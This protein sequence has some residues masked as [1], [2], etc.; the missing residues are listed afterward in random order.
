MALAR[1]AVRLS[2][3]VA[4]PLDSDFA[5]IMPSK[6]L[7]YLDFPSPTPPHGTG[8][9][10]CSSF[11]ARRPPLGQRFCSHHAASKPY[12]LNT[13]NP[14]TIKSSQ[15][16]CLQASQWPRRVTRSANHPPA[17]P[18][19]ERRRARPL[20]AWDPPKITPCPG[21]ASPAEATA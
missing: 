3:H 15:P 16:P 6:L 10:G 14:P 9:L 11:G 17:H 21:S 1:W 18:E 20:P 5:A 7:R 8:S 19:D 13:S 12:P 4:H 2:E